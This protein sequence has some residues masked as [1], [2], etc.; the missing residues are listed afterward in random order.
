M[1]Y[2]LG[3]ESSCDETAAAVIKH[4]C[5]VGRRTL[6][7][8]TLYS[9]MQHHKKFGG[10]V[11]EIASRSHIDKISGIIRQALQEAQIS[12]ADVG[13]IAVTVRPGLPGSLLVG[14][15]FVKSL[16]YARNIP[17]IGV[18]HLEGHI[19]SPFLEHEIP[20]P[21]LS[22]VVSGGHT[23]LYY[24]KDFGDYELITQTSDD[25]VGEAF[26]KVAK[27]L[28]LGYPGGPI[29]EKL[30]HEAH[31]QDSRHYP[32]LKRTDLFLSFS[33]I[34]TAV[35]YDLVARGYY[36]LA[37]R[38]LV[39]HDH[40]NTVEVASSFHVAIGDILC[41]RL[42]QACEL[43]PVK[44]ITLAGGVACNN[45]LRQRS[46]ALATQRGLKFFTPAPRYCTDNA[47]MIAYV[48]SYKAQ[49]GRYDDLSLDIATR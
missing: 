25:A 8:Q 23:A 28:E 42:A 24:V 37:A 1:N 17:I 12:L 35:L 15:C 9:Q 43:R 46:A 11:P 40:A 36:D 38:R 26:D 49:Q 31:F 22:C 30:A 16:C 7:A 48:G 45:Y 6:V 10:V 3:V 13:A 41:H 20:F 39:V 33:G 2:L 18:N 14:L 47:A 34:K 44:A 29:L 21:H 4:P 32:R 19:F 5:Y 27:L